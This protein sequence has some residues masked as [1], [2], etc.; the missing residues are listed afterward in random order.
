[1]KSLFAYSIIRFRPFAE[2][3]E[4]ANIGVIA[5]NFSN[6]QIDF[7]IAPKRLA[8]VRQ[9]FDERAY[10]AYA[11]AIDHLRVEIPRSTEFRTGDLRTDPSVI[12]ADI[13]RPRESS[14]IFS[15]VRAVQ[16][17]LSL[18][19]LTENLFARFVKR[20]FAA[21]SAENVFIKNIRTALLRN[22]LKDFKSFKFD[23]EIIPVSF[24]L[25]KAGAVFRAIKPLAFSQ[26]S[27]MSVVD[28]G[29]HW[30]KRLS[31]LLDRKK[32]DEDS[33]IVA[34]SGPDQDADEAMG[35]AFDLAFNELTRLPFEVVVSNSDGPISEQIIRFAREAGPWQR[36]L[37]H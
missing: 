20:E 8:R 10:L 9:F 6:S 30:R 3:E 17:N 27:P 2:T 1:M 32:V 37:I 31:Y 28:Y 21:D 4:F 7:E 29:A 25:A 12:F 26:K 19:Q 23:D 35:E 34:V 13:V 14:I 15:N 22:G 5:M 24:P 11:K 18:R 36:D 16:S 33:V